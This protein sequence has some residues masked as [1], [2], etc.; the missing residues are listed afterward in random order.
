[1]R[2]TWPTAKV[3]RPTTPKPDTAR[4]SLPRRCTHHADPHGV[5]GPLD[6]TAQA[7]LCRAVHKGA[8]RQ[9]TVGTEPSP[10]DRGDG[11]EIGRHFA[12]RRTLDVPIRPRLESTG[13]SRRCCRRRLC[14]R[15]PCHRPK[16]AS[17]SDELLRSRYSRK[18]TEWPSMRHTCRGRTHGNAGVLRHAKCRMT[19]KVRRRRPRTSAG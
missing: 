12:R 4:T 5:D 19:R 3:R 17:T 14:R 11:G 10:D 1:M 9:A 2:P 8:S 16:R 18:A 7:T 15:R 13:R 6:D